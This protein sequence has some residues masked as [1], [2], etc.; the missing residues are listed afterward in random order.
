MNKGPNFSLILNRP[1]RGEIAL[2]EFHL[3][4]I[5]QKNHPENFIDIT[6]EQLDSTYENPNRLLKRICFDRSDSHYHH[7]TAHILDFQKIDSD[8]SFLNFKISR[9]NDGHK[10]RLA[11]GVNDENVF[12]TIAVKRDDEL[13][14]AWTS[15]KAI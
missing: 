15:I 6:C 14:E 12:Y 1:I 13:P 5:N 2:V 8:D 10:I 4:N 3:P 9:A 11:R 7:F